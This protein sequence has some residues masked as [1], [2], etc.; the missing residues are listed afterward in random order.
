MYLGVDKDD[1]GEFKTNVQE[2]NK[3]IT[4]IVS[5]LNLLFTYLS[6]NGGGTNS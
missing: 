6:K 4:E 5:R 1:D 3:D 2:A